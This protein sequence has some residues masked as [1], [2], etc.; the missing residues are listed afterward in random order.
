ML[1]FAL[2]H[3]NRA[4]LCYLFST[5]GLELALGCAAS[6][7]TITTS[8][9]KCEVGFCEVLLNLV[10]LLGGALSSLKAI[11]HVCSV[12]A[13]PHASEFERAIEGVIVL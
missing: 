11:I 7:L 8:L 2:T 3:L 6:S 12:A 1:V 10:V 5:W 9:L 4:W 13:H